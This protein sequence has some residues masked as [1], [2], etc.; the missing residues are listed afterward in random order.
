MDD[1]VKLDNVIGAAMELPVGDVKEGD[2]VEPVD[3]TTEEL[4]TLVGRVDGAK[5]LGERGVGVDS[6]RVR[7]VDDGIAELPILLDRLMEG[8]DDMSAERVGPEMGLGRDTVKP[9]LCVD[10]NTKEPPVVVDVTRLR[11]AEL[12]DELVNVAGAL[13]IVGTFEP[14]RGAE[15]VPPGVLGSALELRPDRL[16]DKATD[17]VIVF[18]RVETVDGERIVDSVETE[19]DSPLLIVATLVEAGNDGYGLCG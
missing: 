3:G 16:L 9:S 7:L 15:D 18:E 2:E 12:P 10:G 19:A 4:S 14:V 6:D 13:E 8:L 17:E 5:L 1:V 11:V